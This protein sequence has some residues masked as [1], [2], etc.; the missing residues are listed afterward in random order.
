MPNR[1]L[2]LVVLLVVLCPLALA[3]AADLSLDGQAHLAQL[4]GLPLSVTLTGTPGAE[5]FLLMDVSPGP[6]V[7]FG[8][9]VELGLT[10][11]MLLLALGPLPPSGELTLNGTVPMPESAIGQTVHLLAVVASD[12]SPL[13]WEISGGASLTM[14]DRDVQLAG[15]ALAGFPFVEHVKA[16]N[17]G[18]PVAA[19]VDPGLYPWVAG[20][21]A[22]V[23]VVAHKS[24][25]EWL[26]DR[27]LTDVSAS[28]PETFAFAAGSV[29]ANT[30]VVDGGT[31]SA[32]AAPG[33]ALG[34]PYD[35]VVDLDQDGLFD[36][37]DLIDG[38]DPVEAG[39]YVVHDLQLPGPHAV[40]EIIYSGGTWLGQDTYYPSDIAGLGELP[41]LVVSHGNGHNYQ[42]YDHIGNQM[43]SYGWVV[44][45]HQNNTVPGIEAASTTTLT[46]TEYLLGNLGTIGGGALA[47]HVDT[48][49]IVWIGHSRGGEGVAR[50]YDRLVEGAFV[51]VGY[52]AADIKLISSIAPTDFLGP[53]SSDPHDKPYHLWVGGADAD[54]TGCADN[55]I[56]QSFHLLSRAQ[57]SRW[58]IS[59]HGVGHGDFHAST[60]SVAT[61]PCL[62]GKP[63]THTIMRG[64]LPALAEHVVRG[65]IPAGDF[66]WRQWESFRPLGA[67]D[68]NA[69]VVVDLT[70]SEAGPAVAV[71]DDFQSNSALDLSSSGGLVSGSATLVAEGL[72]NDPDTTF[73]W[74]SED[75]SGFTWC[76]AGDRE[77]CLVLQFDGSGDKDLAFELVPALQDARGY[78]WLSFRAAQITRSPLTTAAL[79]DLTFA[80]T[81]TDLDGASA[82]VSIG[83][84]GGGIEEPYQ[85]TSCGTGAGWGN[86]LETIRI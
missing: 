36:G 64:Y 49:A 14:L 66:L 69:C 76:R 79:G 77:R 19:A 21:T 5:A 42:W 68:G 12:P 35:I 16:F 59:L 17:A 84:Y 47:G 57:G 67:P 9:P 56:A 48:N 62:V 41:L 85:R 70:A 25:A 54:V 71:I 55:D 27:T 8:Q 4:Q 63:S 2:V 60:G 30:L 43:A 75:F 32:V 33:V 53:A 6:A 80:V 52:T 18:R 29:A 20:A 15:N 83:A 39:L 72:L 23:Y 24:R 38:F 51:P 46:N 13:N 26:A 61:G 45:S 1:R 22:D 11:A 65:N 10:P 31:L 37:H 44:M 3:R 40:T 78:R 34:V 58:S 86:E 7:L 82:T 81:L 74:D 50:A 28:G 73:T